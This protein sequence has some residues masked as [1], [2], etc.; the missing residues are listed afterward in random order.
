MEPKK[1]DLV[2]PGDARPA[3]QNP[4]WANLIPGQNPS[5]LE[6]NPEVAEI[7]CEARM[8]GLPIYKCAALA[9]ISKAAVTAWKKKAEE[10]LEPFASFWL[11]FEQ[12]DAIAQLNCLDVVDGTIAGDAVSAAQ[13]AAATW[14]LEHKWPS[15][16]N[17]KIIEADGSVALI[18]V[19]SSDVLAELSRE[20]RRKLAGLPNDNE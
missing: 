5:T 18:P 8:K 3:R 10:G 14:K 17:R 7:M 6:K 11:R 13:F 15:D 1:L 9:G 20:E 2:R 12:A 16:F 4:G 19:V